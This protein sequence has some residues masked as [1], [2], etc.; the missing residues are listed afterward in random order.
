M[1][2]PQ[3]MAL[4]HVTLLCRVF[5]SAAAL[6]TFPELPLTGLWFAGHDITVLDSPDTMKNL[7]VI[8]KRKM[9]CCILQ[10]TNK[11]IKLVEF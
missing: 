2:H 5:L 11:K 6:R 3:S 9:R 1:W 7:W 8:I 10:L 4:I